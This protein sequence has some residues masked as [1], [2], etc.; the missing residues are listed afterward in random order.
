MAINGLWYVMMVYVM[1]HFDLVA[2]DAPVTCPFCLPGESGTAGTASN[3]RQLGAAAAPEVCR[4]EL[5]EDECKMNPAELEVAALKLADVNDTASYWAQC[6]A[7][8]QTPTGA[9]DIE[10]GDTL[11]YTL[12]FVAIGWIVALNQALIVLDIAHR[13]RLLLTFSGAHEGDEAVPDLLEQLQKQLLPRNRMAAARAAF[14]DRA[15]A[16]KSKMSRAD[17]TDLQ[18]EEE[19]EEDDEVN[20]AEAGDLHYRNLVQLDVEEDEMLADHVMVFQ[21]PGSARKGKTRHKTSDDVLSLKSFDLLM[22]V[23]MSWQLIIDFYFSF[24]W[25]HMAQRVPK[26]FG[27]EGISDGDGIKQ[28]MLHAA[29]IVPV[30]MTLYLLMITTRQIALLKGVLHMDEDSVG[31][32][33]THMDRVT[34]IRTRIRDTLAKMKGKKHKKDVKSAKA[35]LEK[36]ERGELAVLEILAQRKMAER[37]TRKEMVDI[38][39]SNEHLSIKKKSLNKFLDRDSAKAFELLSIADQAT[40]L[41]A[42]TLKIADSGDADDT[43]E[44]WDFSTLIVRKIAEKLLHATEMCA[45]PEEV[46]ALH[47][48]ITALG[49]VDDKMVDYSERLSQAKSLFKET[50]KD[51]SG[52]VSRNELYGALKRFHVPI[53]KSDFKAIFRVI[54]PDQSMSMSMSEWVDF[55][56]A[57]DDDF[58]VRSH[59]SKRCVGANR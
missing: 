14:E 29:I 44:V 13:M 19:E 54:D 6:S 20:M 38:L 2:T 8:A 22:F 15:M 12:L 27:R 45:P 11:L 55:M 49:S 25:V 48:K 36:A 18:E 40:A 3:R 21:V 47:A 30:V 5:F 28:L 46:K 23:S 42:K 56:M 59:S 26:A 39:N 43:I 34:A 1:P 33:L 31:A 58:E 52:D 7:C 50:D 41:T 16:M 32:V 51:G 17:S 10:A 9:G 4:A 35:M 37:I 57:T 24:Y 53:N